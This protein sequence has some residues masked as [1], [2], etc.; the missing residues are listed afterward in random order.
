MWKG[1][2]LTLCLFWRGVFDAS[3]KMA[4]FYGLYTWLTHTIFGINIVFIP[5]GES[6]CSQRIMLSLNVHMPRRSHGLR[7]YLNASFL[8]RS[9]GCHPGC[10]AVLGDLL[11]SGAGYV[12][13]VAGA[14]R[15]CQGPPAAHLPSA[16]DVFRGYRHLLGYIGV[17]MWEQHRH[18]WAPVTVYVTHWRPGC[19][20]INFAASDSRNNNNITVEWRV[21]LQVSCK[22]QRRLPYVSF[23]VPASTELLPQLKVFKPFNAFL[24]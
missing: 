7:S 24:V 3:L 20:L 1:L 18:S 15:R 5:S 8:A 12:W 11:G 17:R 10:R 13:P 21:M 22:Q 14:G 19:R 4:G 2:C 16:S 6:T 23:G 9:S